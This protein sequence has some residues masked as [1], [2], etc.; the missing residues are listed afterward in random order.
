MTND[1]NI[2][3]L[4]GRVTAS[5]PPPAPGPGAVHAIR[6][7]VTATGTD[8]RPTVDSIDVACRTDS[9]IRAAARLAVGDRVVVE[10][11]LRPRLRR[12]GGPEG[13][14]YEVEAVRVRRP[15]VRAAG[16]RAGRRHPP[17]GGWARRVVPAGPRPSVERRT[18]GQRSSSP[19]MNASRRARPRSSGRCSGGDFMR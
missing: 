4:V 7:T 11:S 14:G 3:R 16:G 18:R 5:A 17:G 19:A 12:H 15:V 2:V 10:G 13:S 6:V 1:E 8:H 9:T